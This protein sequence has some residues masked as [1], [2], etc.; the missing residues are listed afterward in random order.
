M[1]RER[2]KKKKKVKKKRKELGGDFVVI[3]RHT[4]EDRWRSVGWEVREELA[5]SIVGKS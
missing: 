1:T 4:G 3:R 2:V 5:G